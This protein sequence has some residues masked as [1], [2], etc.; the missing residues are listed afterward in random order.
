LAICDA[1]PE[2]L[3]TKKDPSAIT[4]AA[5][6]ISILFRRRRTI[7]HPAGGLGDHFS[8]ALRAKSQADLRGLKWWAALRYVAT[9][10][11]I[12]VS[13]SAMKKF[14][15]SRASRLCVCSRRTSH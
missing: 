1:A 7:S 11:P 12:P 14:N 5:P 13:T 2:A 6:A 8:E 4:S 3:T 10:G 9:K 15:Q